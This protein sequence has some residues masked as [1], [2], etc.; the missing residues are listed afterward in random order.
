MTWHASLSLVYGL[1]AERSVA[2]FVHDGPLRVLKSL[3]PEGDAVCHNVLVHP[4]GGLVGGDT[5]DIAVHVGTGAHGLIT[6]P[7]ATRFY[8]SSGALALQRSALRVEA[9]ARLEWLPMESI[10]YNGC[11]A[12]NHLSLELAPGAELI[13]WDVTALGLPHAGQAYLSGRFCQHIELPGIWLERG[14]LDAADTRLLAGP[15]GLAGHACMASVF[16]ATGNPLGRARRELAL[17]TARQIMAAHALKATAGAT[18]PN[19]QVVV[20]RVLAPQ[21]ES[22][23]SLLRGVWAAWRQALWTLP[24][25]PPRIWAT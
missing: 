15:L 16:F 18:S 8:R 22:A 25:V 21:V 13:G 10:L 23:M 24:A 14:L 19:P 20:L 3:Y 6:T 2:R 4:P 1:E 9:G 12:E 7:G 11:Q 5:L 17:D